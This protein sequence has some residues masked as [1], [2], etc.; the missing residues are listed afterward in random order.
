MPLKS[1]SKKGII[2][3][4]LHHFKQKELHSGKGGPLVEN[5]KQA[6]AIALSESRRKG[7]K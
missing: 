1:K 7:Y 5:R 4:E 2:E 6:I 3:E